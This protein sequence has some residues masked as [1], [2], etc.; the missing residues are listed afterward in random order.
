MLEFALSPEQAAAV[1]RSPALAARRY[2]RPRSA[3][4]R[5][6]WH[7]TAQADLAALGVAVAEEAG[8]WRL[9]RLVPAEGDDWLPAAP[10][11]V[12]ASALSLAA[13]DLATP[14]PLVPVAAF[15][16]TRR[17]VPLSPLPE[18]P[19]LEILEGSVRGVAQDEPC[20]RLIL[21]GPAQAMAELAGECGAEW[22]L[23]PP[24]CGLAATALAVA[25]GAAPAPRRAGAPRL[26]RGISIDAALVRVI[27]H[28][29]E[30]ILYGATQVPQA[31]PPEPV[32][33]MRV[34]VRR[35]RSALSVFRRAAQDPT[36]ASL[37]ADL[38]ALAALL[39]AARDWD[40][41]LLETGAA[42]QEAF[43]ADKRIAA[44][45]AAAGKRRLAAYEALRAYFA[46]A[47]WRH[48]ALRLALLPSLRPWHSA[49]A[50]EHPLDQQAEPYAAAALH[51][52]FR[53]A[54]AEG[55]AFD[56]LPIEALH[57]LRKRL[58]KLRYATEFFAPLFP[59]KA[60]RRFAERLQEMQAHLGTL[61]DG[62]VAA[63]LMAQLGG[64]ADRAFATGVVL[65][66]TAARHALEREE[67]ARAWRKL[68]RSDPFWE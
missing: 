8:I 55:E 7:D 54:A 39:G 59:Q 30:V 22:G 52:A 44:M 3:K 42:V 45:L 20:C 38:K 63:H 36:L 48:L 68:L 57:D 17:I 5:I 13:L 41:F 47:A 29:A 9:E 4:L 12:L 62:A 61:N 11:P 60:V 15:T 34:A 1:L 6:I 46:S 32:H 49:E 19:R 16:G 2:G 26:P 66:F 53:R 33:Q 35:L 58:K 10:A 37:A 67:A 64:G 40:V 23:L 50:A 65:G 56:T 18:G 14:A 43:A 25:R 27:A 21:A 31:P 28:L 51:R 24:S